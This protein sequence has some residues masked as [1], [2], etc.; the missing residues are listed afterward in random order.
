MPSFAELH[1]PG[2]P[3]RLLNAWDAGSAK[4]FADAGAKAIATTSAAVAFALG[5]PDGEAIGRDDVVEATR[6][7]A[8]AVDLPVTA[9]IEAG[10][11]ET[12][13]EVGET[14]RAIIGAGAVGVN[15]EDGTG[16]WDAP[17][18]DVAGNVA[19]LEAARAA[20][21]AEGVPLFINARTDVYLAG[22]GEPETRLDAA[23]L[24]MQAYARAGASGVFVPLAIDPDTIAALVA[25]TPL[26]LNVLGTG[27]PPVDELAALGVARVSVGS[28]PSL[29][30]LGLLQR[31]AHEFLEQGTY[32]L[33]DEGAMSYPDANRLFG[34]A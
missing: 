6:R 16:D 22:V 10:F 28:G 15:I 21:D 30:A 2:D 17:L 13:Q 19:R 11:G 7:I 25:A 33:M 14:V 31:I 34:G 20:A 26:P 5:R 32:D 23:T 18:R 12:P 3:L 27:A 24:R 1:V 9:D 8:D 4:L 29:A